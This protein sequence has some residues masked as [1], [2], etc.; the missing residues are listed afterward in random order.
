MY[1]ILSF[2]MLIFVFCVHT[3]S[4]VD[5]ATVDKQK[6]LTT[7]IEEVQQ[8]LS[9]KLGKTIP[10]IN[11]LINAPEYQVYLNVLSELKWLSKK[12]NVLVIRHKTT[13]NRFL[14][15][16]AKAKSR[17]KKRFGLVLD[18]FL[19]EEFGRINAEPIMLGKQFG[20]SLSVVLLSEQEHDSIF[21]PIDSGW[22]RF[23]AKYPRSG[24]IIE[25]S[26]VA[27]DSAK[28]KALLYCGTIF[29]HGKGG[30][31]YYILLKKR[32]GKWIIEKKVMAWIA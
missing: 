12:K 24:G 31:G 16:D 14:N 29:D 32:D 3:V 30:I 4:A 28:T 27:F 18:D 23:Y 1:R 22:E 17:V 7:A 19:F 10:S 21:D 5:K 26:R 2:M 11:V 6:N 8:R 20:D 25:L 13:C 15:Y 9:E